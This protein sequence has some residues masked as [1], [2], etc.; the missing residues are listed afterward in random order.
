MEASKHQVEQERIRRVY[1]QWTAGAAM[2]QYA[3]HRPEIQQQLAARSRTLA[4]LL[5]GALGTDLSSARIL[6]VGCGTGAFLRQ[7]IAWG[8]DPAK[9]TGTEFLQ[10]RLDHARRHTAAGVEWHLGGLDCAAPGSQDLATAETV[11]SSILDPEL[12]RALAADMWRAV[13][14]GGWCMVFDFRYNNPRNPNVRKVTHHELRQ[15]WPAQQ[16]HYRTL[17]LAPPIARRLAN[18][19]YLATELLAAVLPP[20]RS[21]FIWM[22]RKP[23]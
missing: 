3:W 10:D 20:L 17:L 6:D 22:A 18:A 5:A 13:K 4:P 9:L 16:T 19:P 1:Q 12:R 21:H 15:Y 8:A 7:L 2:T 23:G 11:F 14:P